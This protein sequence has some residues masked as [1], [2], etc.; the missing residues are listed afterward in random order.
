[1]KTI[2]YNIVNI[3]T[4]FFLS[5]RNFMVKNISCYPVKILISAYLCRRSGNA[6]MTDSFVVPVAVIPCVM[7]ET[8]AKIKKMK[9]KA[10]FKNSTSTLTREMKGTYRNL[11]QK[12]T[13]KANPIQSQSKAKQTQFSACPQP[14]LPTAAAV[15]GYFGE[16]LNFCPPTEAS[17]MRPLS[18]IRNTAIPSL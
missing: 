8:Q 9:S 4:L 18:V 12:P 10:N 5:F 14:A 11:P 2:L 16:Y 3:L 7:S 17:T 13:K 6:L 1:M 15:L